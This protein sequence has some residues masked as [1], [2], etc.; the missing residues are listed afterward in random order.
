M[1]EQWPAPSQAVQAHWHRRAGP[2]TGSLTCPSLLKAV[3]LE[4][5]QG[6][7]SEPR[8]AP[9]SRLAGGHD[10]QRQGPQT[11]KP[12]R[13]RSRGRAG[14][15]LARRP[16]AA[17]GWGCSESSTAA[18]S[19]QTARRCLRRR[20]EC[21]PCP[22]ASSTRDPPAQ[23]AWPPA[24]CPPETGPPQSAGRR[25]SLVGGGR[26]ASESESII[27]HATPHTKTPAPPGP[28]ESQHQRACK[29]A[30]AAAAAQR[31]RR[32]RQPEPQHACGTPVKR[33]ST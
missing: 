19:V 17:V 24:P 27:K 10:Y 6:T 5:L 23:G 18:P 21:R 20:L 30:A 22:G 9:Q 11:R 1:T 16:S 13:K 31:R 26:E 3:P 32:R 28:G 12:V 15:T 29:V 33:V 14:Q 4:S 25:V 8:Q 2:G 7:Q